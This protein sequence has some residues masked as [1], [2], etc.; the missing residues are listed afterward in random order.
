MRKHCNIVVV[1]RATSPIL[2]SYL[3]VECGGLFRSWYLWRSRQWGPICTRDWEP[4]TIT[5]PPALSL[6]EKVEMVQVRRFTLCLRH[7]RS[8]WMQDGRKVYMDSYMASNGTCFMV[9]W[10]AFK[11]HLLE[12][13][14]TQNRETIALQTL[15][16]VDL[17]YFYHVWGPAWL[18][19]H[20]NGNWLRVHSH[21]T[22]HY[23]WGFV[24]HCMTLKV[25]WDGLWTLSFGLSQFHGHGS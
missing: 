24:T 6:V 7:Q 16:T 3:R 13:G 11:N 15:V 8:M 22:S 10:T 9:T 25:C 18:E 1:P 20:W 23:I 19:I 21:L 17:F 2:L 14:L 5:L 12:V 4:M